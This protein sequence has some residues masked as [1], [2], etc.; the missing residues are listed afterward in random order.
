LL[1][2]FFAEVVAAGTRFIPLA[3]YE[4][5]DFH[6]SHPLENRL[7]ALNESAKSWKIDD[8]KGPLR[9]D[10]GRGR[11]EAPDRFFAL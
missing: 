1:T 11:T 6:P 9:R 3:E 10:P 2:E 5:R 4:P 7:A 8:R